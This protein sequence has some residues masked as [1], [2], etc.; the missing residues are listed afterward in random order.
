MTDQLRP[1]DRKPAPIFFF[2][3]LGIITLAA[4][5]LTVP[6]V[7]E[8]R[9]LL[10]GLLLC[11]VAPLDLWVELR[12]P[13]EETLWTQ[14]LMD[15]LAILC[16]VHLV[17]HLWHTVLVLGL[18]VA[19]APSVSESPRSWLYYALFSMLLVPGMALA[20]WSHDVQGWVL[21][22]AAAAAVYPSV[23]FYAFWTSRRAENL[24]NRA[25]ALTQLN[26]VAG[27]LAH[28]FNNLLAGIMGNAELSLQDMPA[29]HPARGSME[30]VVEGAE[31]AALLSSQLLRFSGR[32]PIN[33]NQV[34]LVTEARVLASLLR[35]A[36]P[37][38]INLVV[39][40]NETS[41]LVEG[42]Q[43]EIQQ[44]L[45]NLILNTADAY[46]DQ[47]GDVEI[48]LQRH[49]DRAEVVLIDRGQ[50]GSNTRLTSLLGAFFST[51]ESGRRL[52]LA[53]SRR[54]ASEH[55]GQLS[56]E[57][58]S[59]RGYITRLTLPIAPT[60]RQETEVSNSPSR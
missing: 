48:D 10:A 21:P 16:L 58:V 59:E 2:R 42:R 18:I 60:T 13:T 37:K 12:F 11:V 30:S 15:L 46:G 9:I 34:D 26:Q 35:P 56:L 27:G 29:G 4:L 36:V 6:A 41:L 32:S 52:G 14:P 1:G 28:D 17:P 44:L 39:K 23:I 3:I 20:A 53:S 7:G 22:L 24:R 57:G 5:C 31:Q 54:V 38:G 45:M 47:I 8:N 33:R 19:L 43:P 40:T 55:G 51:E 49:G 25:H 50:G